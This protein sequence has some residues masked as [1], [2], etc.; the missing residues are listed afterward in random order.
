MK[1]D[2]SS[3]VP[4][5]EYSKVKGSYSPSSDDGTDSSGSLLNPMWL[6]EMLQTVCVDFVHA[7][8]QVLL[9]L[10]WIGIILLYH[11]FLGESLYKLY[12]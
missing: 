11:V 4:M 2:S 9:G 10:F 6:V 1:K 3:T 12:D 7:N 5:D 8:G